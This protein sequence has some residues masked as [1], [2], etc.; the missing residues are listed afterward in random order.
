MEE[1][2]DV[3]V[4]QTGQEKTGCHRQKVQERQAS[5]AS[6]VSDLGQIHFLPL[7]LFFLISKM[8]PAS[9]KECDVRLR[10]KNLGSGFVCHWWSM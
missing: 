5:A 6:C 4:E 2:E 7:S 3:C 10:G 8:G 1:G 9:S